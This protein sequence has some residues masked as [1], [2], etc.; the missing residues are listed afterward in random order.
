V[1]IELTRVN[2]AADQEIGAGSMALGCA[3]SQ[4]LNKNRDFWGDKQVPQQKAAVSRLATPY[5]KD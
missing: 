3:L 5:C 2:K 4:L 1:S